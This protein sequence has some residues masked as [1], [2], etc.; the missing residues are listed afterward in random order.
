VELLKSQVLY[1]LQFKVG[2]S[3]LPF[4]LFFLKKKQS[5]IFPFFSRSFSCLAVRQRRRV[6][7]V[8]PPRASLAAR[9]PLPLIREIYPKVN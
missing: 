7:R 3:Y 6:A 8:P 1:Q 5:I 4:S 9:A 2:E